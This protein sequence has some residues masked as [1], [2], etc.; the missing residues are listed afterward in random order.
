MRG[1]LE[2]CGLTVMAEAAFRRARDMSPA[3]T[4]FADQLLAAAWPSKVPR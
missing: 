4:R 2:H 3:T 1:E